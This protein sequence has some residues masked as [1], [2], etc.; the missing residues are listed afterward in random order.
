MV[1]EKRL[2]NAKKDISC[3]VFD[4]ICSDRFKIQILKHLNTITYL[5]AHST[6]WTVVPGHVDTYESNS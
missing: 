4:A 5:N 2:L 3:C 6:M 1:N